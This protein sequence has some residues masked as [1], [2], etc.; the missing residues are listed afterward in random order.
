M[1]ERR[2]PIDV[3]AEPKA[4]MCYPTLHAERPEWMRNDRKDP[5]GTNFKRREMFKREGDATMQSEHSL[6]T[7]DYLLNPVPPRTKHGRGKRKFFL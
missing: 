5:M 7:V 6:Q 4:M 2:T 3:I 1:D